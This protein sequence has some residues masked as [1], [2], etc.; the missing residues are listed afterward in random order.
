MTG[1]VARPDD[2]VADQL[3]DVAAA[4]AEVMPELR[5][6]R[7]MG[8]AFLALCCIV[9]AVAMVAVLSSPDTES[10][11]IFVAFPWL[12][13]AY[14]IVEWVRNRQDSR[15]MPLLAGAIGLRHDKSARGFRESLPERLLPQHLIE[16]QDLLTGT[17]GGREIAFAEVKVETGGKNSKTLFKGFVIRVPNVALM[18]AF[19][20]APL[21]EVKAA[22]FFGT[23]RLS[24]TGLVPLREIAIGGQRF[25]L[26]GSENTP[27]ECPALDGVLQVLVS[28]PERIGR[29]VD[30]YAITSN[31]EVMHVA[32]SHQGDL[33]AIGGMLQSPED[34]AR[35]VARAFSE[36]TIPVT[37]VGAVLDAEAA[38]ANGK[39][40]EDAPAPLN[41]P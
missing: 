23:P 12:V 4:V 8:F 25:G 14:S 26:F 5:K 29:G 20:L 3:P 37:L 10:Y 22:G 18:P 24:S 39:R 27:P 13:V 16:V 9:G 31:R 1:S 32:L 19:F 28:L 7:A 33:F 38:A 41:Q 15:V 11:W 6:I 36:L 30:I 17:A 35:R 34:I 21:D 40:R 2:P